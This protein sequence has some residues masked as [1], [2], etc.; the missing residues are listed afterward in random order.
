MS[1][2]LLGLN[3]LAGELAVPG[4]EG[5]TNR[6]LQPK[7]LHPLGSEEKVSRIKQPPKLFSKSL[8]I[9]YHIPYPFE[10]LRFCLDLHCQTH[11]FKFAVS[12]CIYVEKCKCA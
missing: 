9:F 7:G 12:P 11:Y 5:V 6:Y 10:E 3:G 4:E 8:V 1:W 2:R